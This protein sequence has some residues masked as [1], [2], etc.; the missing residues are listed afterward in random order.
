MRL[1]TVAATARFFR[2]WNKQRNTCGLRRNAAAWLA[3]PRASSTANSWRKWRR[4]G[5]K[6]PRR[7]IRRALIYRADRMLP[8][9]RGAVPGAATLAPFATRRPAPWDLGACSP[10]PNSA[11][12]DADTRLIA[13]SGPPRL[14][15]STRGAARVF[16]LARRMVSEGSMRLGS[17]SER[18]GRGARC[19]DC[20]LGHRAEGARPRRSDVEPR[21]SGLWRGLHTS[22]WTCALE[23]DQINS[24]WRACFAARSL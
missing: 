5:R 7:P 17:P 24:P 3:R 19:Q 15:T 12:R 23:G 10:S 6:S 20:H 18:T 9:R 11:W 22:R 13:P 4:P 2:T 14:V 16:R 21:Q 1:G 8:L